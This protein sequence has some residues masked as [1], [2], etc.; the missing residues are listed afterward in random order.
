MTKVRL[1][2]ERC[3][4]GRKHGSSQIEEGYEAAVS[5]APLIDVDLTRPREL[6]EALYFDSGTQQLFGWL[7]R[8]SGET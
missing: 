7:H 6:A 2:G 5:A 3:N 1:R 4:R 8:P